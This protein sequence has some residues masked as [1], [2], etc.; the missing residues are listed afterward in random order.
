MQVF[1]NEE[2]VLWLSGPFPTTITVTT[3]VPWSKHFIAHDIDGRYF[4]I[5]ISPGYEKH[6]GIRYP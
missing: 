6:L 4:E 1:P 3:Q 2:F 5:L